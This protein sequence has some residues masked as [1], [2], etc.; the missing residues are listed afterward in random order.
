VAVRQ[1]VGVLERVSF[2]EIGSS[3]HSIQAGEKVVME[4]A[5]AEASGLQILIDSW[6]KGKA[7][8]RI[9]QRA[10]Q[11]VAK[12]LRGSGGRCG[13]CAK[14]AALLR[15]KA[16]MLHSSTLASAAASALGNDQ[17]RDVTERLEDLIS[18]LNQEQRTEGEHKSWCESE[19]R[20]TS[21]R[22]DSHAYAVENIQAEINSLTELVGMKS[23][24]Y[25][26]NREDY[27]DDNKAMSERTEIRETDH[28]EYEEDVQDAQDAIDAMNQAIDILSKFYATRKKD[29]AALVQGMAGQRTD[30]NS[31]SQVV[32]LLS[33]TRNT[34]AEAVVDLKKHENT[35]VTMFAEARQDHQTT[36]SDLNHNADV[37][38]V[39]KQTADQSLNTN[40][41]DLSTNKGEIAAATSYLRRLASSCDPLIENF[42]SRNK[43]RDEEKSA[44]QDAIKVL[45]EV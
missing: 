36:E 41:E 18:N 20:R 11:Q 30:P 13:N 37:V 32:G 26:G 34:F 24:E 8:S 1:A 23:V 21:Q 14:V 12:H 7:F 27:T 29:G 43:L 19:Q 33:S 31:G 40:R 42:E 10:K 44:I 25:S 28:H 4:L 45:K 38:T 17:L 5:S 15:Q 3:H 22:R 35:E 39:E 6:G 9:A 2:V 16:S